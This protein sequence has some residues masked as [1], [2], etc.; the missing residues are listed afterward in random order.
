MCTELQHSIKTGSAYILTHFATFA[1]VV[2][3]TLIESQI[4]KLHKSEILQNLLVSAQ[5][6]QT[7]KVYVC[8]ESVQ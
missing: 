3:C 2:A 7:F 1:S 8:S 6:A 5:S 4:V